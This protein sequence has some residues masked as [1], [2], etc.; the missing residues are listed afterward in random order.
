MVGMRMIETDDVFAALAALALNLHQL[1]RVDVVAV[2]RRIRTGIAATNR[3]SH[4]ARVA[5]YRT[6]Q[7][8]ATLMGI[9][10][11]AMKAKGRVGGL[12]KL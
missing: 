3:V 2:L 6:Q 5:I 8:P 4:H 9:G 1:A 10:L 12:G 7:N 11:F